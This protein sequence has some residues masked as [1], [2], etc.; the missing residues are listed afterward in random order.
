[1]DAAK[2]WT[3]LILLAILI[4][5]IF[6]YR[7]LELVDKANADFIMARDALHIAEDSLKSRST[8]LEGMA[9]AMTAAK[10]KYQQAEDAHAKAVAAKEKADG[11]LAEAETFRRKVESDLQYIANSMPPA[12]EKTRA[13]AVGTVLPS[14]QLGDG[15][16]LL[17][18]QIKKIEDTGIS[19]IH[20]EGFGIVPVENLPADLIQKYDMGPSS[21]VKQAE[22]L[23]TEAERIAATESKSATSG[24]MSSTSSVINNT[25]IHVTDRT[26]KKTASV[27]DEAK[28][29]KIELQMAEVKAKISAVIRNRSGW[30]DAAEKY[31]D[32]VHDA[33]IRGV[34]TT[35]LREAE[36][37]ARTQIALTIQQL[38]QL[39]SEYRRLDVEWNAASRGV[40]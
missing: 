40:K 26:E 11:L 14:V 6:L 16:S 20:S 3:P 4:G 7:H 9:K 25:T 37:N 24:G 32:Q 29:K 17:K 21:L 18:A 8:H 38:N 36:S 19:F 22:K 23:K 5:G 34:P 1:M 39:E 35:K 12:V 15:K 28:L 31:A 10:E 27:I 13:A 33:G 30:E 2:V